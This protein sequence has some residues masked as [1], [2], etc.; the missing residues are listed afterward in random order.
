MDEST[1][2]FPVNAMVA[3]YHDSFPLC[4]SFEMNATLTRLIL[5]NS[6]VPCEYWW[7]E[8]MYKDYPRWINKQYFLPLITSNITGGKEFRAIPCRCEINEKC[9][10]CGGSKLRKFKIHYRATHGDPAIGPSGL[11]VLS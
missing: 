4:I 10:L 2:I 3:V 11:P 8:H 5:A 9:S 6:K 7:V 1:S